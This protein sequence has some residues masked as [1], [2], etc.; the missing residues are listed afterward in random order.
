MKR[1]LLAATLA[2]LAACQAEPPAGVAVAS[3]TCR[4]TIGERKVTAC[5]LELTSGRGDRL[6][7]VSTPAAGRAELHEMTTEGGIMR[8]AAMPNGLALPAGKTVSLAPG[9]DHIMLLDLRAG[10]EAGATVEL[11]LTFEKAAPVEVIAKVAQPGA[12]TAGH[13]GHGA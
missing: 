13:E 10:L 7:S 5:Y 2:V 11:T 6:V 3:A 1:I 12:P 9:G 8:M 4:P